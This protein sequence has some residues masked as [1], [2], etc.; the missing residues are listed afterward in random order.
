VRTAIDTNVISAIWS[1]EASVPLLLPKLERARSEGARIICIAVW[2][3]LHAYP[4][5]T[6]E[7]I[8][9]ALHSSGI[10]VDFEIKPAVWKE[11]ALR[12]KSYSER[13]RSSRGDSPRRLVTDFLIGAHAL[14]QADRLLT[15][16]TGIYQRNFPELLLL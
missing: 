10:D 4:G 8:E 6:P 15:L 11:A 12:Y 13:R 3:E 9:K 14:L 1:K 16:D 5:A 7:W 2:A